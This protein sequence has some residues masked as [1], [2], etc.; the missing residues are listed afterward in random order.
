M[1]KEE[2]EE[3]RTSLLFFSGCETK[4]EGKSETEKRRFTESFQFEATPFL[5]DASWSC[6]LR[7]V[8]ESERRFTE[9]PPE[10]SSSAKSGSVGVSVVF[11]LMFYHRILHL[12]QI[13][14][15]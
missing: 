9:S 15:S 14:V 3:S 4:L 1:W 8:H 10:D 2:E 5:S 12:E 13:T 7:R 6:W 11:L